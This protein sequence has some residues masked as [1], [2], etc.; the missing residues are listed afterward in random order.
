MHISLPIFLS[1]L[2]DISFAEATK[3]AQEKRQGVQVINAKGKQKV[4]DSILEDLK[5]LSLH[6][7]FSTWFNLYAGNERKKGREDFPLS[8]DDA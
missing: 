7:L 6:G 8:F 5:P 4:S 1:F 2:G 3:I